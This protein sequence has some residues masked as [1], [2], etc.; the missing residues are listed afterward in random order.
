MLVGDLKALGLSDNETRVYLALVS[1]GKVRA[2]KIIKETGLHRNLVYQA[3]EELIARH[4]T[5]KTTQA[6]VF[7]FQATDP[8]HFRDELREREL[9]AARVIDQLKDRGKLSE[10]E[11]TL[12]EGEDAI[13]TFSLKC[14]SGL[15]RGER[16]H[17]LG[18]GG[19]R[20]E[21]AMGQPALKKYFFDI[22]RSG[23][24]IDLLMYK[25]QM[26]GADMLS[27]LRKNRSVEIR[28]LPFDTLSAAAIVFT[29]KS[30]AFLIFERPYT[31]IEITNP[32]LVVA[33][34]NYFQ[35]L[36]NQD[37][38]V[39]QGLDALR[40]AFTEMI[41]ELK[42]GEG[43]QVL[44]GNLGS[45]YKR[46]SSFFDDIHRY[47]ISR[48]VVANILAQREIAINIRERNHRVGDPE[49][50]LSHV[51]T[52]NTPFLAPMQINMVNGRAFMVL[53]KEDKPTIIYFKDK[54][55]HDGFKLYFDEIWTRQTETLHGHE[56]IVELCER[57]LEQDKDLYY[58][59]AIGALL[60]RQP[61]YY[62]EFTKRRAAKN[63]H[64][65]V[66]ANEDIRGVFDPLPLTDVRYLPQEFASPMVIWIFGDFV[67]HVLW[68][69]PETIFLIHDQKTADYYRNYYKALTKIAKK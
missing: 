67:A 3:L 23:G 50:K 12:Y 15:T 68:H 38:R 27:S 63:I 8:E 51:K 28:I 44:G 29:N 52:F 62:V 36:W 55:V 34:K 39:E 65:H 58:I 37:V 61:E 59:A 19:P 66:L 25:R 69:E 64:F 7:H 30:V 4:L 11:I 33:Y 31:V 14:A 1:I 2:G 22:E 32:H 53:Y 42:P 41:D 18:S 46:L 10:Q 43:Y 13:R 47:R 9:V 35:M 17:V 57:V 40:E 24:G 54:V 60:K 48:G 26:Y 21:E 6:G 56:G 20:F 45:E 49:D 16:I 5:T